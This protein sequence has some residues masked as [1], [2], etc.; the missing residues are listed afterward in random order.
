MS[1]EIVEKPF[2][3]SESESIADRSIF[4][5]G[6]FGVHYFPIPQSETENVRR[7]VSVLQMIMNLPR[8]KLSKKWIY[9]LTRKWS[10]N[11]FNA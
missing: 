8:E 11:R 9:G 10:A 6:L 3:S 7:T 1:N 5:L 2:D 4:S